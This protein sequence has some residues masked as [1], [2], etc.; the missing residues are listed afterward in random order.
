[1]Q[2]R[3]ASEVDIF[4]G[5]IGAVWALGTA[6]HPVVS[7]SDLAGPQQTPGGKIKGK[8]GIASGN[9]DASVRIARAGVDALA[10][11]VNRGRRPDACARGTVELG[12]GGTGLID[13]RRIGNG[14]GLPDDAASF[15]IERRHATAK[16]AA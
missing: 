3:R 6:A 8:N 15:G 16:G 13:F 10:L 1:M 7:W 11:R 14:V 12:A 2:N 9:A 5:I 4:T